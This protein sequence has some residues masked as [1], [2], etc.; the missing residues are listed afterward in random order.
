VLTWEVIVCP[1]GVNE[2]DAIEGRVECPVYRV[3]AASEMLV[4][5]HYP[6]AIRVKYIGWTEIVC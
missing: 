5:L 2:L 1:E 4:R 3:F 6:R